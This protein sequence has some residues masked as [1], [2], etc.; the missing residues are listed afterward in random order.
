MTHALYRFW[1]A[2]GRL[3]YVGITYRIEHR[4]SR[5]SKVKP[6][7]EIA[8][9]TIEH[10]PSRQEAEEAEKRAIQAEHPRWNVVHNRPVAP[11]PVPPTPPVRAPVDPCECSQCHRHIAKQRTHYVLDGTVWCLRCAERALLTRGVLG[12]CAY[13]RHVL[14]GVE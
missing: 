2:D 13:A 4:F 11:K 1:S 7:D 8:S 6:W 9:V 14:G 5:H 12:S 3:L 10:H